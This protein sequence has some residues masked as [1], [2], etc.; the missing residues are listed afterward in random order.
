MSLSLR[1][2]LKR[3]SSNAVTRRKA[4]NKYYERRI[5]RHGLHIYKGH[6]NWSL[7]EELADLHERWG[8]TPGIPAD[9]CTF[10][11][12]LARQVAARGV[13]G[14]TAECGVRFGKSS[15]FLLNAFQQPERLH[16]IFD[17]FSGL[18]EVSDEDVAIDGVKA[19]TAGEIAADEQ[20]CRDKLAAYGNCRFYR[21]WIPERF[22]EIA[23]RTFALVHVDVDLYEPT[24]DALEFFWPRL[25]PGG[26]IVSD[27]YGFAT[28]PGVTRA[29]DEFFADRGEK[30]L[31]IPSG[32]VVVWKD[33]CT[34]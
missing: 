5:R 11:F 25:S 12:D 2:F 22:P 26:V 9:R 13:P 29:F 32:Q 30:P 3:H 23:D 15:F 33:R 7:S 16:H 27:D 21:G 20:V 10:L 34:D 14:D 4:W 24:R 28:C 31:P 1:N 8:A 19:W 6:L 18:S 17:S